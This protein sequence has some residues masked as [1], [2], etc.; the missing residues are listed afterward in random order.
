MP[1]LVM[2]GI[3]Y[4]NPESFTKYNE[5][6]TTHFMWPE[7]Y[8]TDSKNSR[9]CV[10]SHICLLSTLWSSTRSLSFRLGDQILVLV[11]LPPTRA[12]CSVDL[13][14]LI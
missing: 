10:L 6:S 11:Y 14:V 4:I 12:T 8:H 2:Y 3:K 13:S 9:D 1:Q 7:S 5:H